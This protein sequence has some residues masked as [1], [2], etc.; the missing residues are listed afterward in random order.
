MIPVIPIPFPGPPSRHSKEGL[1]IITILL[2][3]PYLG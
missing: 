2:D 1:M 3:T